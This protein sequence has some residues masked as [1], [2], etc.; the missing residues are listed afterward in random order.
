MPCH[1]LPARRS[2]SKKEAPHL[3]LKKVSTFCEPLGC[4][5]LSTATRLLHSVSQPLFLMSC[6]PF[7]HFLYLYF[8]PFFEV[9]RCRLFATLLVVFSQRVS[10][11]WSGGRHPKLE[12]PA[13]QEAT[14]KEARGW[15]PVFHKANSPKDVIF[16]HGHNCTYWWPGA[17]AATK[18]IKEAPLYEK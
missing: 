6:P 10:E 8:P 3:S 4:G 9:C 11:F 7:P 13:G 17:G 15:G 14:I 12:N 16:P 2:S 1:G 18:K 5:R